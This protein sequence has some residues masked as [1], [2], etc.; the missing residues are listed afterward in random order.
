MQRPWQTV[1]EAGL[2][3]GGPRDSLLSGTTVSG[4]RRVRA[5]RKK[6]GEQPGSGGEAKAVVGGVASHKL[7]RAGDSYRNEGFL[8]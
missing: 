5:E 1:W 4:A 2:L 3:P 6:R 8:T 7:W